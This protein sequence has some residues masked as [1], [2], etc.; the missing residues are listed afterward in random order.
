MKVTWEAG[1][2]SYLCSEHFTENDYYTGSLKRRRLTA[3]AVPSK[4][5]F[6]K[7]NVIDSARTQR[8]NTSYLSLSTVSVPSTSKTTDRV[9]RE[10]I[11]SFRNK[12]RNAGKR[13]KRL[14][15]TVQ[16]LMTELK[17]LNLLN[18]DLQEKLHCFKGM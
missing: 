18:S 3:T 10:R 14:R 2:S 13:E 7:S 16:T 17:D 1:T 6:K 9:L 12:L 8:Y 15:L 11:E 4:F 5:S